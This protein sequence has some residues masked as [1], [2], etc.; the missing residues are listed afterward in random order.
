MGSK[1]LIVDDEPAARFGISKAL[2]REGYTIAEA[3]DVASAEAVLHT[4]DPGVVILDI[5][6]A[7]ES[8]LDYLPSLV[9]QGCACRIGRNRAG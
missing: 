7:N 4:F 3:P 5:K 1:I 6:L 8:G 9:S 2:E